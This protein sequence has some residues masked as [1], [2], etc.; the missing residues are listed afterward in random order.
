MQVLKN[1]ILWLCLI[2]GI[3]ISISAG[4]Y[5]VTGMMTV[6]SG[7]ALAVAILIGSVEFAKLVVASALKIYWND[8]PRTF[9]GQFLKWYLSIAVLV[10]MLL[11]SGGIYGFLS[12]A[13]QETKDQF[14]QI[15]RKIEIV[16]KKK[17][18]YDSRLTDAQSER[19]T[20]I[21]DIAVLR[22][23]VSGNV[24]QYRDRVT[25][26]II[27]STSNKQRQLLREQLDDAT[28]R[29]NTLD[30][31][32]PIYYDSLLALDIQIADM[33]LNNE[34]AKELGPIR[35]I[36]DTMGWDMNNSINIYLLLIMFVFDPFALGCILFFTTVLGKNKEEDENNNKSNS[37]PI[38]IVNTTDEVIEEDIEEEVTEEDKIVNN[39]P[40]EEEFHIR[41]FSSDRLRPVKPIIDVSMPE[42]VSSAYT[43]SAD[44]PQTNSFTDESSFPDVG[45]MFSE[46]LARSSK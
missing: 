19:D 28:S 44:L 16:E 46:S 37:E 5:S 12:G 17:V 11:T 33:N 43:K 26:Q 22:S 6:F 2:I 18:S 14:T 4:I 7:K 40:K 9:S 3:S 31:I 27:T 30:S 32:I 34:A 15:N 38:R 1:T 21:K 13:F 20:L 8:F 36:S 29:R 25:G 42:L 45:E 41:D 24:V 39:P 23:G 35:Y 10:I